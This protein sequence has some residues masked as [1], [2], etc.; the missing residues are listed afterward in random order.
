M[1][2]SRGAHGVGE[3]GCCAAEF[4]ASLR[5]Q[6]RELAMGTGLV[7]G[8]LAFLR[9]WNDG[10]DD[11]RRQSLVPHA[12]ACATLVWTGDGEAC[13]CWTVTD[14][15]VREH[16]PLW[17]SVLGFDADADRLA[18]LGAV[19]TAA[20]AER[21][22]PLLADVQGRLRER[23]KALRGQNRGAIEPADVAGHASRAAGGDAALAAVT[24][25]ARARGSVVVERAA[26][27]A[28]R[29]AARETDDQAWA[30]VR[31]AAM[32][33]GKLALAAEPTRAALAVAGLARSVV[34]SA[35]WAAETLPTREAVRE[36]ETTGYGAA[37]RLL[38]A[39]LEED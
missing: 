30:R 10:L 35:P 8:A 2:L 24:E 17:L 27:A 13:R 12:H 33:A 28:A 29:E 38:P 23:G 16:A 4:V 11:E 15:L 18:R 9:T 31:S 1:L 6:S 20:A 22:E 34:R 26:R 32:R 21:A 14:W 37:R 19:G 36:A 25:A 7:G 5:G 3:S 39:L